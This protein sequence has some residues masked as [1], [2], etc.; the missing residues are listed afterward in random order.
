MII[1]C[2]T[3]WGNSVGGGHQSSLHMERYVHVTSASFLG[4]NMALFPSICSQRSETRQ[5]YTRWSNITRAHSAGSETTVVA[6]EGKR[7][8]V[9]CVCGLVCLSEMKKSF[10]DMMPLFFFMC[11]LGKEV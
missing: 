1:N 2:G 3:N 5:V 11:W 10:L 9:L 8:L 4:R 6:E 7:T